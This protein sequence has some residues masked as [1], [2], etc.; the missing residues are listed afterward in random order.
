MNKDSKSL[1]WGILLILVGL[2]LLGNNLEWFD[3]EWDEFWPLLMIFGGIMFWIGWLINR[4]EYRLLMPGTILLV[5]GIM[6]QY[7]ARVGWY[8]MENLWPGFLLGPGLGFFAMYLFGNRDKGLLI[9]GTI[10]TILAFLFWSGKYTF[11]FFWPIVIIAVGIYL[12]IKSRAKR[13]ETLPKPESDQG[14]VIEE[15]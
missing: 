7:S 4:K 2:I 3:V 10:L 6:F 11:H 15:K 8:H 14:D 9:P 1:V 12:I 5:Y 13:E